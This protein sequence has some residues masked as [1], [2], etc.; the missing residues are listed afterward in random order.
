MGI[1]WKKISDRILEGD[2]G[3]GVVAV[4]EP[5]VGGL[6]AGW[7]QASIIDTTHTQP[8]WADSGWGTVEEARDA[9]E[10]AFAAGAWK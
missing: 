9:A 4:V 8:G 2:C 10:R 5:S 1:E 3:D 7:F 6:D